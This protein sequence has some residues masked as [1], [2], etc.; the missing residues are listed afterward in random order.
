[1]IG[2]IIQY[3]RGQTIAQLRHRGASIGN[4]VH[5]HSA[6]IDK[7][8]AC[9]IEIGNDVSISNS[10]VLAH[11]ASTK[12]E[13]GYTKAL[14]TKI[15]SKVFI[16]AGSVVCPGSSIGDRVIVGAGSVI[17]GQIPGNSV[18]I[19]NPAKVICSYDEYMKKNRDKMNQNIFEK[20]INNMTLKEKDL[21]LKTIDEKTMVFER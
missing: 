16:G 6:T 4:N 18:V 9:L 7:E 3:L 19:G 12:K 17:R 20:E 13:L 2:F 5:F 8:T 11:D 14:K 10:I 21:V 15:G 1:M